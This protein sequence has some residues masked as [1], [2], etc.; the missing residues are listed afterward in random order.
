MLIADFFSEKVEVISIK[1]SPL[2]LVSVKQF[3]LIQSATRINLCD[4]TFCKLRFTL[5]DFV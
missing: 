1:D 5:M 4:R 2:T 3:P